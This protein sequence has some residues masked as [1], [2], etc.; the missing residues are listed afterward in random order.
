MIKNDEHKILQIIKFSPPIVILLASIAITF[1]IYVDYK[2]TL[3]V[4]KSQIKSSFINKKKEFIKEHVEIAIR[5]ANRELKN[6]ELTLRKKLSHQLINA[7]TIINSIYKNNKDTKTKEE[8]TELIKD[9][10]RD[11]RFNKG[12]GYFFIHEMNGINVLHPILPQR[13]GMDIS[14]KRD[15]NG[16]TKIQS[17]SKYC[18]REYIRL[19]NI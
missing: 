1:L 19:C 12:R 11:I 17:C 14:K 13:E 18:R 9:A 5:Y 2:N 10:L 4:E 6:T 8:I 16:N 3:E 7:K 15:K